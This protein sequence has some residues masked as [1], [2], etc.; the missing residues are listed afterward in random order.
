MKRTS[1]H[2]FFTGHMS[3]KEQMPGFVVYAWMFTVEE[4]F[5]DYLM[6]LVT[7]FNMLIEN[8]LW[9]IGDK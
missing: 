9:C 1:N 2:D 5:E 4:Y 6:P 7:A 3:V 8:E